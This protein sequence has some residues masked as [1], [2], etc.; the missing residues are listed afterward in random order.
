VPVCRFGRLVAAGI[1]GL[2]AFGDATGNQRQVLGSRIVGI[3][4]LV[5]YGW[6]LLRLAFV[7]RWP[8]AVG[9]LRWTTLSEYEP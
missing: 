7:A 5:G 6:I 3:F 4:M 1:G 8:A 2:F 9:F